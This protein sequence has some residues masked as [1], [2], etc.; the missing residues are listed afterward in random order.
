MAGFVVFGHDEVHYYASLDFKLAED[1]RWLNHLL[2]DLLRS[3]PP[4][5]W[6]LAWLL[7]WL[8]VL[9]GIGRALGYTRIEAFVPAGTILVAYPFALQAPWPATTAPALLALIVLQQLRRQ[10]APLPALYILGGIAM[11]GSM[12]SFYLLLPLIFIGELLD[13]GTPPAGKW[14]R[15]VVHLAWWGAG[16]CIGVLAMSSVVWM[17]SGQFG[18]R[19]ATWRMAQ[20]AGDIPELLRNV[21]LIVAAFLVQWRQFMSTSGLDAP[22]ML[23]AIGTLAALRLRRG[24]DVLPALALASAV[25][26]GFFVMS[27]PLAPIIESRSLVA[28]GAG[29]IAGVALLGGRDDR[30]RALACLVL[31]PIAWQLAAASHDLLQTHANET[32]A[33][34][35]R[36]VQLVPAP[37]ESYSGVAVCGSMPPQAPASAIYNDMSRLHG[38]LIAMGARRTMNCRAGGDQACVVAVDPASI[39]AIPYAAGELWFARGRD[40]GAARLGWRTRSDAPAPPEQLCSD[41]SG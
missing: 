4:Q 5:A 30:G 39:D 17:L 28:L 10:G 9:H 25:A 41:L 15:L 31:V 24:G 11:F 40:D 19:P 21:Q 6:A 14:K 8:V 38:L 7:G 12:Q 33:L 22:W 18:V 37:L 1:G 32:R 26:L 35:D 36:I 3:Q 23:L 27:I 2:N 13:P 20:P 34:R 16:A 29:I